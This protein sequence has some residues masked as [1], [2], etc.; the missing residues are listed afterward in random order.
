M[1]EDEE[2]WEC[3]QTLRQIW[4]FSTLCACCR[5]TQCEEKNCIWFIFKASLLKKTQMILQVLS[6]GCLSGTHSPV[7]HLQTWD[8]LFTLRE[9]YLRVVWAT[10]SVCT[11]VHKMT[12]PEDLICLTPV[13]ILNVNSAAGSSG[14]EPNLSTWVRLGKQQRANSSLTALTQS[15][16]LLHFILTLLSSFTLCDCYLTLSW[17][18]ELEYR[19][20]QPWKGIN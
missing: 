13:W 9:C 20:C 1:Q 5:G 16:P 19:P 10:A 11:V 14:C 4:R 8:R 17:W 2:W 15:R 12:Q 6:W 3:K 18:K 7:F